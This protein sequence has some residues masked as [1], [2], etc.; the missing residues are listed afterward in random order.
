MTHLGKRQLG[1]AQA[2]LNSVGAEL[3]PD[4]SAESDGIP[5]ELQRC[6]R[7]LEND[8]GCDDQENILEH[9]RES[10]H[11]GGSFANL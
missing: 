8:H 5:E 9:T 6:H 7:V 11:N 3:V 2:V 10:E 1:I 4:Q